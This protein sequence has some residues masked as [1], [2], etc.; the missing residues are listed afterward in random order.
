LTEKGKKRGG[1][2]LKCSQR[3]CGAG[4]PE[5]GKKKRRKIFPK[6]KKL[7]LLKRNADGGGGGN[8]KKMDDGKAPC[9]NR[10]R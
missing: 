5:G 7:T 1:P 9:G 10:V 8:R 2:Q 4:Y 3:C 6:G